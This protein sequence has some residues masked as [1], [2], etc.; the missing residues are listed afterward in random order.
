MVY[1]YAV[2]N[3]QELRRWLIE[4][5][6]FVAKYWPNVLPCKSFELEVSLANNV[7]ALP[8]DQRYGVEDM[9]RIVSIINEFDK[10]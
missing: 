4:N 6:V 8:I 5:K 1:P 2:S 7:M 10:R 3:G 9:E